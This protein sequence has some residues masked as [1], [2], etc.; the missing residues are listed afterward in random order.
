MSLKGLVISMASSN[1]RKRAAREHQQ[2]FPGTPYPVA[3][4]AVS[5]GE[6]ALQVVIGKAGG[7]PYWVDIEEAAS[8]GNGPHIAVIGTSEVGRRSVVDLMIDSM[9]ARPPQ[10]GV[11]VLTTRGDIS[12]TDHLIEERTRQLQQCGVRDFAELRRRSATEQSDPGDRSHAVVVVVDGDR[13]MEEFVPVAT[14]EGRVTRA[15]ADESLSALARLLRRG[16]CLDVHTV[17]NVRQLSGPWL[18]SL[19]GLMSSVVEVD[20][21]GTAATWRNVGVRSAPVDVVLPMNNEGKQS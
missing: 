3:L 10:R 21:S 11:E 19:S 6:E 1:A 7:H 9:S 2:R 5:H 15:G 18:T 16:R 13:L 4:R 8:G 17:L 14:R 12:G 20:E